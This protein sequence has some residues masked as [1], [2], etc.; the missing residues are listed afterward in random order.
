[1][2]LSGVPLSDARTAELWRAL[3][4]GSLSRLE[5]RECGLRA[6]LVVSLGKRLE[7]DAALTELN[8]SFNTLGGAGASALCDVL[9]VSFSPPPPHGPRLSTRAVPVLE[10]KRCPNAAL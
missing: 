5:L 4:A 1:M 3:A 8:L 6:D 10:I 9:K 7:S 2:D